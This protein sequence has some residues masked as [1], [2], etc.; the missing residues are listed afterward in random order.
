M[1]APTFIQEAET[2]WNTATTPKGSGDFTTSTGDVVVVAMANESGGNFNP[3]LVATGSNVTLTSR[4]YDDEG[5]ACSVGL[6]A[7]VVAS[8]GTTSASISNAQSNWFGGNALTFRGTDGIGA[9]V[10]STTVGAGTISIT[11]TQANSAIVV[12]V[13]DWA[14]ASPGSWN[15]SVGTPTEVTSFNDGAHYTVQIAYYADAGSVGSKTVGVTGGTQRTVAA[16]EI[17]GTAGGGGSSIAP[18]AAYYNRLRASQ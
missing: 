2:A 17:K 4:A 3:D 16:I 11:T 14:A 13:G 10:A 7:G 5:S 9:A 8:G 18:I 6:D 15:T 12:V 1:A